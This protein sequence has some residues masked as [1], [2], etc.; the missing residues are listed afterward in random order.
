M[1]ASDIFPRNCGFYP[2][3]RRLVDPHTI[4]IRQDLTN[5]VTSV[6][7]DVNVP[8][9]QT[10]Y[11]FITP[12]TPIFPGYWRM[13]ATV[14]EVFYPYGYYCYRTFYYYPPGRYYYP[15]VLANYS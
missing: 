4:P 7:P 1:S 6:I 5:A 12:Y 15:H 9:I 13:T 8:V 14:T 2:Y 11:P 10:Y 3:V